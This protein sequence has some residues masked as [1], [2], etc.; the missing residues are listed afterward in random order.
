MQSPARGRKGQSH[1]ED[2]ES[3]TGD[4]LQAMLF[5]E[6]D[7]D[8]DIEGET[9]TSASLGH[10]SLSLK[11]GGFDLG[12]TAEDLIK[13]PITYDTRDGYNRE[14]GKFLVYLYN[15][16]EE[17]VLTL[18]ATLNFAQVMR[19]IDRNKCNT[20][21]ECQSDLEKQM[22][23][24]GKKLAADPDNPPID[25]DEMTAAN[26]GLTSYSYTDSRKIYK[27]IHLIDI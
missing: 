6:E 21:E 14:N 5:E 13:A 9:H 3:C 20:E 1:D 12:I 7:K 16:M 19:D 25:F 27:K 8:R 10:I 23:A 17:D 18:H 4:P 26:L 11:A 24:R 15:D 22:R 2:D